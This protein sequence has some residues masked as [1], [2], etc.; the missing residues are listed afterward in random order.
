MTDRPLSVGMNL[1]YL[2]HGS[3]GSDRYARE[4][5][6][7]LLTVE[8]ATRLTLFV[9]SSAPADLFREPW[10]GSVRFHRFPVPGAGSA[11]HLLSE[12]AGIPLAAR[13]YGLD[14]VHGLANVTPPRVAGVPSVVTL[15]DLIWLRHRGTMTARETLGMKLVAPT[16]A[17]WADRVIAISEAAK[18][19]MVESLRLPPGKIDVVYHGV[20]APERAEPLAPEE[21]S[22][23]FGL[24]GRPLVLC[25]AQKRVHK[26]LHGLIRGV[27]AAEEEV[28]L[29]LPGAATPY[30]DELRGLAGE[31]GVAARVR[32]LPWVDD[33]ELEALYEAATCFVLPSFEEGFGLPV[34][35]AMRRGVP[36]ACSDASSLPEVAGDAALLFD[37]HDARAIGE[38]VNR[39][40]RDGDLRQRLVERGAERCATFTWEESARRTLAVYRRAISS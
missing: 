39:L 7:A 28:E 25:V 4:L 19:D 40:V 24:S 23:R 27:A 30:E 20:R 32:F 17:R 26:N 35:E 12:V 3:G 34:L 16:S 36:V 22:R 11:W 37:P 10:A 9:S 33:D 15:H 31:L 5:I 2:M 1:V 21:L 6:R 38:A 13:R 14:A 18:R 29:V 8:P